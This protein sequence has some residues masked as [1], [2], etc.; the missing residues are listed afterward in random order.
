MRGTSET[1]FLSSQRG[2]V[3]VRVAPP[4]P[5]REEAL[6]SPHFMFPWGTN[7]KRPLGQQLLQF[8]SPTRLPSPALPLPMHF[9][10]QALLSS[11]FQ[12]ACSPWHSSP[13]PLPRARSPRY[14]SPP[15][16]AFLIALAPLLPV[17]TPFFYSS[18]ALVYFFRLTKKEEK[19]ISTISKKKIQASSGRSL[20]GLPMNMTG[21]KLYGLPTATHKQ[22]R[23]DKVSSSALDKSARKLLGI[24]FLLGVS[25]GSACGVCQS[26]K[27]CCNVSVFS[28]QGPYR[29]LDVSNDPSNCGGCFNSCYNNSTCVNGKCV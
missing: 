4:G 28:L 18:C 17:Q 20:S 24:P 2:N 10:P 15:L 9:L 16:P 13:P 22:A 26:P 14:S 1:S 8:F 23:G 12:R 27:I 19:I 29:C 5:A 6:F 7:E 3:P 25:T 21:R 11:S